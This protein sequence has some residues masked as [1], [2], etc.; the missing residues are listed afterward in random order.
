MVILVLAA[1]TAVGTFAQTTQSITLEEAIMLART[2]SVDA[3]VAL[4][5]L[6]TAYWSY[7]TYRADLLPE[8]NFNAT[9]PSYRK[10][11]STY[12]HDDGSYS[13]VR[14]N[15]MQ[16]TGELS[17]DQNIWLTGGKLSLNTSLDFLKQLENPRYN[18]FM[19]VPIALTLSQPI[20][21]V[22]SIKW[23]R[24]IEPV[25]YAEAK[26]SFI[27]AS[28]D[29]ALKAI[30]YFFNLLLAKENVGIASQNLANARKLYEVA[31]A[32]REMGQISKN[33]L[34]Q[35]ELNLLNAQSKATD[36]ESNYR[37][38]MF[39]LRAFLDLGEDVTPDPVVPT[40][41]PSVLVS[42][43]DVLEK[44]HAN[45]SFAK[46]IRRRQL[47][48]DYAVAKA[49]GDQREITLFAQVGYTGTADRFGPAYDRLKD[50]QIVEIGF[51]IPILDWGKRRGKVKVS[52]S[53]RE[54]VQSR[55]RKEQMD[56]DQN[57]FIL[58]ER[59]NNQQQQLAI[60]L[61]ADTIAQRRYD[62]NVETFLIGKIS[63]LDLNDSQVS[64]DQSRQDYINQLY[65]YWNYYYQLRSVALWDFVTNKD[66]D[67]DIEKIVKR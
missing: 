49:K 2:N 38:S 45:N 56:F 8:V 67:A 6:R 12:Q 37:S 35:L 55:L 11:Y 62:T 66:I 47:E 4:N 44:A 57:I 16:M 48:A 1:A 60:S 3:A 50:N 27:S 64:K 32:K 28:E 13:F 17:I 52:E 46:N 65:L 40:A 58:C 36:C 9:V 63:T 21:G 7:R 42:Y 41:V 54:V 15:Y 30:Q 29:V 43:P 23:N 33:D 31:K 18:R 26:A 53:N 22:N 5:E 24:R 34:L 14:N 20:F 10:S 39:Q 51:K 59:F 61:R 25:R 19:S